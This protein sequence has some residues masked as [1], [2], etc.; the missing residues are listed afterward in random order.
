M[1]NDEPRHLIDS[2]P[3]RAA[4]VHDLE[5][6]LRPM[7]EHWP[8]ELFRSMVDGL[9]N[10]TLKYEGLASPS[11]FDPRTRDRLVNDIGAALGRRRRDD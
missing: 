9:A 6:R 1:A 8:A 5:I 2:D 10:V 7:C 4:I 11:I 3:R